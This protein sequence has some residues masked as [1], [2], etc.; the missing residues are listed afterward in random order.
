LDRPIEIVVAGAH[1]RVL[2]GRAADGR[3]VA[4][5]IAALP[6][7][8]RPIRFGVLFDRS[9]STADPIDGHGMSAV[10]VWNAARNAL[11]IAVANALSEQ[12]VLSL[13][14]FDNRVEFPGE[15]SGAAAGALI[16]Q[17]GNPQ[18]GT[19]IGAALE[20]AL[21]Q[22]AIRDVVVV[23]DGRSGAL[24][25]QSLAA[26][27][28]RVSAILVGANSLEAMIGHLVALTGGQIVVASSSNIAEAFAAVIAASR[29]PGAPAQ[30]AELTGL[31]RACVEHRGGAEIS[32]VWSDGPAGL[33]ATADEVGAYAAAIALPRLTVE[34]ATRVA[35]AHGLCTH[36]TSLVVVDEAGARQ[37]GLPNTRKVP[38]SRPME[39]APHAAVPAFRRANEER[40]RGVSEEVG[41]GVSIDARQRSRIG[42]TRHLLDNGDRSQ[43]SEVDELNAALTFV[44]GQINWLEDPDRLMKGEID[45]LSTN[46]GVWIARLARHADVIKLADRVGKSPFIVVIGL[47]AREAG[48]DN[49]NAARIARAILGSERLATTPAD[50]SQNAGNALP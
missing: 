7:G 43:I 28:K 40:G 18:G 26:R 36:L 15:A 11:S 41:R 3:D 16:G 35:V 5:S 42:G 17:I 44:S 48:P 14:Q 50:A 8:E 22:E 45:H 30:A 2:S 21:A 32:A 31:P 27:G 19:A 33:G 23:T 47:L 9:G 39:S 1:N 12:D 4:L 20:A 6:A 25:V 34:A 13:W 24:D 37:A 49:R 46:L 10:S 38:L 29:A